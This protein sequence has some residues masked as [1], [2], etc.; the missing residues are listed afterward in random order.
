[1]LSIWVG[2]V[3]FVPGGIVASRRARKYWRGDLSDLPSRVGGSILPVS[4]RTAA[5]I[6]SAALSAGSGALLIPVIALTN[7]AGSN[8]LG[9]VLAIITALL[10]VS[11]AVF[12]IL[13]L[14]IYQT[15]KPTWLVPPP[16]RK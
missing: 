4:R 14:V 13:C 6:A 9:V 16:L 5:S 7:W 15:N 12:G 3:V 11:C 10:A 8:A 2:E 1:M